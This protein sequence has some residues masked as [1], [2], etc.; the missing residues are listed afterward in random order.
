MKELIYNNLTNGNEIL[1]ILLAILYFVVP[2]L[3]I[4]FAIAGVIKLVD[5][6]NLNREIKAFEKNRDLYEFAQRKYR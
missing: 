5:Y 4:G 6:I 3:V 1:G 2:V